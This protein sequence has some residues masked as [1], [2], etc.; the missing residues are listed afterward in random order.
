MIPAWDVQ[1]QCEVLVRPYILVMSGD[2]PMQ[3][4]ECSSTGLN[5]CL[6][7]RTCMVGGTN[8]YKASDEGYSNLFTVSV[9]AILLRSLNAV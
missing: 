4:M 9:L 7:C 6:F 2:N 5:S 3:A 1:N 8:E